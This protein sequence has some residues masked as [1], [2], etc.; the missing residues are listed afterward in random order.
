MDVVGIVSA[1]ISVFGA[2]LTGLLGYWYERRSKASDRRDYMNRYGSSLAWAAFDLQSRVFNILRG[3]EVDS[4]GINRGFLTA[5][6]RHGDEG[7]AEYARRSTAFVFAEYLG[8]VEILRRDVQFLELGRS[9]TNRR[10]MRQLSQIGETLNRIKGGR[11]DIGSEFRIFRAEQRAMGDLMIHPEGGPSDR[12]CLG[13]AEFCV[14]LD[15]DE[16]FTRWFA[17]LLG[18][19]ERCAATPDPAFGR[20]INLQHQLVDLLELL[21]PDF[22]RFSEELRT[23]F[24][25]A[26]RDRPAAGVA[27]QTP[28]PVL[29]TA[30]DTTG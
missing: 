22:I 1:V 28:E 21:D 11:L 10:V 29:P 30:I 3:P 12:R 20:L 24:A 16:R 2:T 7:D 15:E 26:T 27:S 18:D 9:R 23:R 4:A 8:W 14:R 25:Y 13:Y 17:K 5:F 6:M 19:V